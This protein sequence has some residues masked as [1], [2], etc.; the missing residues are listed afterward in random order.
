MT[1]DSL[2]SDWATL[3]AEY[4][5]RNQTYTIDGKN[6]QHGFVTAYEISCEALAAL[7]H[8]EETEWGAI[9]LK[10]PK[11]PDILPRWDDICVAVV[12]LADQRGGLEYRLADGS[13]LAPLGGTWTIIP[14]NGTPPRLGPNIDAARG[15][16]PAYVFPDVQP[17]LR[18][19]ELIDDGGWRMD[20]AAETIF[21]RVN[22]RE[23][24]VE[25]EA[26]HRFAAAVERA[27]S[28]VPGDVREIMDRLATVTDK[29]VEAVLAKSAA[30]YE[31]MLGKY[32]LKAAKHAY[33]TSEQARKSIEA[34][35]SYELDW[36][37]F[38][39]WRL[40]DGWLST[41]QAKRALEIFHD[42]LAIAMRRAVIARLYPDLPYLAGR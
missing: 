41:D 24:F 38:R 8:A 3:A 21:W 26:D 29:D 12:Q 20:Q 40:D 35:R 30:L 17:V 10:D 34:G 33:T 14:A 42:P 19:L 13:V 31:E 5:S 1:K 7:G 32:G 25:F 27:S 4:M 2:P 39:R 23:W 9:P 15:L 37:F 16:G 18:A 36:L 22:H 11:L 6:W 28:D